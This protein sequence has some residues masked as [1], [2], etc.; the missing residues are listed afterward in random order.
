[1][2]EILKRLDAIL[3]ALVRLSPEPDPTRDMDD[4]KNRVER[5]G[6]EIIID[7]NGN[8]SIKEI[9][10]DETIKPNGL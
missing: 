4:F 5:S 7:E 10:S 9:I 8:V 6:R 3:A 1:M 2:D